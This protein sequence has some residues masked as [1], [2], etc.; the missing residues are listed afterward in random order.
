VI[1]ASVSVGAIN[2]L[3]LYL[4]HPHCN[5]IS[6]IRHLCSSP[7]IP[8]LLLFKTLLPLLEDELLST[9]FVVVLD[10]LPSTYCGLEATLVVCLCGMVNLLLGFLVLSETMSRLLPLPLVLLDDVIFYKRTK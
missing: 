1:T 8:H 10:D 6:L 4:Y 2:S 3:S 5:T 7:N 9:L